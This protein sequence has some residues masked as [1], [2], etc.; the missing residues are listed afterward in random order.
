MS[1][2][3]KDWSL[4]RRDSITYSLQDLAELAARLGSIVT[5][6]RRGDVIHTETFNHGYSMWIP[7][8]QGPGSATGLNT[9]YFLSSGVSLALTSGANEDGYTL[10]YAFHPYPGDLNMGLEI[11]F[12]LAAETYRFRSALNVY[13]G[14]T[15]HR[16]R[17]SYYPGDET[18][19]YEDVN[20]DEQP[21]ATGL[22]LLES[23]RHF[24]VL[25]F[26]V[27][28]ATQSYTRA[29]LN[30]TEYPLDNPTYYTTPSAL[31]AILQQV[32]ASYSTSGN[33]PTIY[34]DNAIVTQ[35]EP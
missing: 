7:E 26:V 32:F 19:S 1:K 24:H 28:L 25:K 27:D 12:T 15:L 22:T 8:S 5:F 9:S 29:I 33:N 16:A 4:Y 14:T 30:D 21:I 17:V 10:V 23:P 34:I 31:D 6:D 11:H 13:D 2:G 3:A 35:D 20:G 18:L